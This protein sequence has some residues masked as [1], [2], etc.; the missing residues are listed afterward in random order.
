[1]STVVSST[2]PPQCPPGIV[3]AVFSR[4]DDMGLTATKWG[5][6]DLLR[7]EFTTKHLDAM[8]NPIKISK[9]IN[10]NLSRKS[11]LRALYKALLPNS[12]V[13]KSMSLDDL[14]G[15]RCRLMIRER[16]DEDGTVWANIGSGPS[17]PGFLPLTTPQS[18]A[19]LAISDEAVPY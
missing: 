9:R 1:M 6:K 15:L 13:P 19:T 3:E 2:Q 12:P 7:V 11:A 10:K 5:V 17:E 14:L 4:Y 18:S 16:T 8:G